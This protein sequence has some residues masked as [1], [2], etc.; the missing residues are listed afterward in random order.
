MGGAPFKRLATFRRLKMSATQEVTRVKMNDGREVEFSGKRRLL[1]DYGTNPDG[2]VFVRFDFS[3]GEVLKYDF[4]AGSPIL[5]DAAGHGLSQ[6]G[7]DSA[8]GETVV[9]DMVIAVDDTMKRVSAGDWNAK[10]EG[11]GF[12]GAGVVVR[13]LAEH[14][15]K[16]VAQVKE[17][18]DGR[19]KA[20][21]AR[22]EKLTR[23]AIYAAFRQ[24]TS[25]IR[26]IIDRL[27]AAAGGEA[28]KVGEEL[29]AGLAS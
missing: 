22:N 21:E 15:G 12:G 4:A 28:S 14:T 16:T 8:A 3:N 1:K 2:G 6:K 9:D 19:I 24:P 18:I 11:S 20:A 17:Y 25:A 29:L 27:E 7:G 10:R 5:L 13:A 26:P 23:A